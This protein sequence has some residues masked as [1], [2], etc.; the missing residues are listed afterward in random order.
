MLNRINIAPRWIIFC[1]D[2]TCCVFSLLLAYYIRFSIDL[3][4]I[5]LTTLSRNV[6][7][8]IAINSVVFYVMKTYAGI[9]RYITIQD[10]FRIG[11]AVILSNM[12]FLITNLLLTAFHRPF[13]ISNVVLVINGLCSFPLLVMYRVIIRY[14][15]TRLKNT[16]TNQRNI[17]I[18]GA[19][20]IGIA[21]MRSLDHDP[22][23]HMTIVAFIDHDRRKKGKAID[24]IKIYHL[25]DLSQLVSQHQVDEL[26]IA[27]AVSPKEKNRVVDYCLEQ[28]I[29]VL[30]LPPVQNWI[31]GEI[32]ASQIQNIKIE[33][34][35]ERDPI[36]IHNELMAKQLQNKRILVTGA[37]GSIGSEIVRQLVA[38]QPQMIILNDCSETPL[39]DLQLELNE[40]FVEH[41]F[42]CFIGDIRD[43][44]RMEVLFK[45]LRPHYVYHAAAYKH[46]PL[47]ENNPS[48]SVRTNVMGTKIIADLAA[49]YGVDKFVMI[50]TDKA[51][52]P[53]NVMGASKRLAE[54]YVQSLYGLLKQGGGISTNNPKDET[55]LK[56]NTITKFITTRFGNVL[57]SNGSVIPR[58]NAQIKK[59]GPIT[60]THPE[61]TRYFM[62]IPEACKL[63]LEAG[64]M[65]E[66][67]EIYLFDMGK[68][69][70]IV[71][72]AKKMIRLSGLVP[73][74][75]IAI[76][77]TGL[78][79]GEKLYEELLNNQENTLP[80]HHHKIMIAKV[81][82]YDYEGVN[83][84][85]AELIRLS[86]AY[87][88]RKV[89]AKM[90]EMVP[91]FKSN[92]S[93]YEDLDTSSNEDP[94]PTTKRWVTNGQ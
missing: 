82:E 73:N 50:S 92:N 66:G 21:A 49:K 31:N 79:P 13:I 26:L 67:G 33:D 34:L 25:D 93:V 76:E 4:L 17:I 23:V 85:I 69:I 16:G 87:Q 10:S 81:K 11:A 71:D 94:K 63:V 77:F 90:K 42:H 15:F 91:E 62:T 75:D 12:L 30:A 47:M 56:S 6:L 32:D 27:G 54:I 86:C 57:G 72:L 78:R 53:S 1:L 64:S 43:A 7:I 61:I 55:S 60:V 45:T 59:G 84:N 14:T 58:F 52:N 24:G 35:L 29:K 36:H 41:T 46:V 22:N 9:I 65:G 89:V 5:D 20:E 83:H 80:T 44:I 68:S 28:D 40:T 18:Y 70:K 2:L 3:K 48:E 74:Q 19:D 39:H 51:V 88:D 8:S 38:F 37:A